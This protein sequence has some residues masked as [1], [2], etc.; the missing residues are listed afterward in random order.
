[1]IQNRSKFSSIELEP[2]FCDI[3]DRTMGELW[4]DESSVNRAYQPR[5]RGCFS[6]TVFAS[7]VFALDLGSVVQSL[8]CNSSGILLV[9][10]PGCKLC[11]SFCQDQRHF[12][13]FPEE[14]EG[15]QAEPDDGEQADVMNQ[16][17]DFEVCV[18]QGKDCIEFDQL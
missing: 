7:D 9:V 16:L 17:V 14:D 18:E 15:G 6:R 12:R 8:R 1:M 10:R 4:G 13:Y 11:V 2:F 3:V 5:E